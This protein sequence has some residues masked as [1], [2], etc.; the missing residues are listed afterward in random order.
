MEWSERSFLIGMP[1]MIPDQLSEVELL[2]VLGDAQWQS[3]SKILQMPSSQIVNDH[4]ERLYASFINIDVCFAAKTPM[5]LGEGAEVHIRHASRF[6]SRRFVEGF[7]CFDTAHIPPSFG[8][9]IHARDDL[10][11]LDIPWV[12]LTNAFVSRHES[13]LR[14]RTFAPAGGEYGK[15]FTTD[16]VPPGIR[17]HQTVERTGHLALPGIEL[18]V[19]VANT[20]CDQI[21]YDIVPESDLNGAGLLYFARYVAIANYGER[22]FLRRYARVELSSRLIRLLSTRRR[23]I[24]YFANANEDDSIKIRVAAFVSRADDGGLAS[25]T[26]VAPL[27]F[28]FVTELRRQ[29]DGTLMAKSVAQKDLIIAKREKSLIFEAGRIEQQFGLQPTS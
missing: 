11:Q 25:T 14:L 28:Y 15:E 6:Y 23:R 9:E 20:G 3:I 12:Y 22:L 18:A 5:D 2:K 17:D 26:N 8:D 21:V 27:K 13:N 29:S 1:H 7:F 24:F 19:P 16:S 10:E 4:G